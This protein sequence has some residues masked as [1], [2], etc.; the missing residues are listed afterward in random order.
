M[1][2]EEGGE[3]LARR[4]RKRIP[5]GDI[6]AGHCHAHDALDADQRK[7]ARQLRPK[8]ARRNGVALGHPLDLT[9]EAHNRG[10]R[11]TQI[12]EQVSAP[13]DALLRLHIDQEQW[14]HTEGIRTGAQHQIE[15]NFDR[16]PVDGAD[17]QRRK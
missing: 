5:T 1:G 16:R 3:W 2:A 7:A 15:R 14:R 4:N 6:E 8:F 17:G 9:K 13:G 12:A 11:R 10:R